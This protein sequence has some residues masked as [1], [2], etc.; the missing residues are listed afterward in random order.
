LKLAKY[1]LLGGDDCEG[2]IPITDRQ[3]RRV[4]RLAY[5]VAVPD[6]GPNIRRIKAK[7]FEQGRKPCAFALLALVSRG[8]KV[9][10]RKVPSRYAPE[11]IA[12]LV[13]NDPENEP[14]EAASL[15]GETAAAT[16]PAAGSPGAGNATKSR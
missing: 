13:E 15:P 8:G 7:Y 6:D 9:A 2:G 3:I 1:Q 5:G 4:M 16:D 10:G 14:G 11:G 12:W